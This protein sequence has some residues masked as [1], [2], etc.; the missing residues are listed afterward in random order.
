MSKDFVQDAI[1]GTGKGST[2][3]AAGNSGAAFTN[4]SVGSP[5]TTLVGKGNTQ[6]GT[7][8]ATA[9]H[10]GQVMQERLGARYTIQASLPGCQS[11]EA[12][13]TQA[14]GRIV[15]SLINRDNGNFRGGRSD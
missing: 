11:P 13:Q 2:R 8:P 12:C 10:R 3:K 7:D 6:A 14:N 4:V 9:N 5:N 15:P 1:A